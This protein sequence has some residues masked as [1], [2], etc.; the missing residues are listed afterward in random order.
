MQAGVRNNRNTRR[1]RNF[2]G[3]YERIYKK[4]ILSEEAFCADDGYKT[5]GIFNATE[6]EKKISFK[7]ADIGLFGEREYEN[8][9]TGEKVCSGGISAVFPSARKRAFQGEKIKGTHDND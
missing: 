9:W 8:I 1:R 3:D 7:S 2:T 5:V 4:I 6:T